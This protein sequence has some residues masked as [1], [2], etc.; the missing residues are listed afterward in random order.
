MGYPLF[1]IAETILNAK[2]NLYQNFNKMR[3]KTL[4]ARVQNIHTYRH[5]ILKVENL[6]SFK[7]STAIS[8][9]VL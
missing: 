8:K 3:K 1:E 4:T 9:I 5:L 2:N 6:D 7:Q